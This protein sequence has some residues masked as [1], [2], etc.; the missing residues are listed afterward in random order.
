MYFL[1]VG[2][3]EVKF[4]LA[5]DPLV[6]PRARLRDHFHAQLACLRPSG[7][8][9]PLRRRPDDP[10]R[11]A[12]LRVIRSR[13][14]TSHWEPGASR[15]IASQIVAH[16]WDCF[17]VSRHR[18]STTAWLKLCLAGTMGVAPKSPTSTGFAV[19]RLTTASNEA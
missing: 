18:G 17:L 14:A 11:A 13:V 16:H 4:W 12:F 6:I 3:W 9:F 10:M 2:I 8:V 1:I 15:A 19:R 7:P 5:R